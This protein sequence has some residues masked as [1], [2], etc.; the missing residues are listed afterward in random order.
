MSEL[1]L[2]DTQKLRMIP[3][4]REAIDELYKIIVTGDTTNNRPGLMEIIRN[5]DRNVELIKLSIDKDRQR[6]EEL[7]K[8]VKD[9]EERHRLADAQKAE[10]EKRMA[11]RDKYQLVVFGMFITNIGVI[12]MTIL[13]FLK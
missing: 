3:Q 11:K 1:S 10:E 5:T 9:I 4:L 12:I 2:T 8:R 6:V 13:G 7:E